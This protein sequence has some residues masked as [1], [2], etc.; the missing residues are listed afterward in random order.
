MLKRAEAGVL[1]VAYIG[2]RPPSDRTST[3]S[4]LMEKMNQNQGI[5]IPIDAVY[6]LGMPGN[7]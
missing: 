7:G 2:R 5:A 1:S 6:F 4:F 3:V